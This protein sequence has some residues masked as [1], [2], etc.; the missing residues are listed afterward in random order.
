MKHS[1]LLLLLAG[2]LLFGG[3]AALSQTTETFDGMTTGQRIG[4]QTGWYDGGTG[5]TIGATSGV[6]SSKGLGTSA[7]VFTWTANAFNWNDAAFTSVTL[8]LDFQSS[9]SGTFDDDRVA[10]TISST[11]LG[12]EYE[13]GVQL[14][15][16]SGNNLTTYWRSNIASDTRVQTPIVALTGIANNTWYRL[17][18]TITKLTST[19]A[20]IDVSLQRLDASGNP[21][22]TPLTGS[23]PN[24]STWAGGAPDNAY[25]TAT[26]MWPSFKNHNTLAGAADNAYFEEGPGPDFSLIVLPDL[27]NMSQS[28][29][30]VLNSM[31]QW[32]AD[33]KTTNN[34]AF[35]TQVGDIVNT[36]SSAAQW[37][38]ADAA[39]DIVDAAGVPYSVSPGNHDLGGLYESYFGVAR[40]TGKSWYG[41]HYNTDNLNSYSLFSGSGND[42]IVINLQYS[43]GTA[44]LDWADALLKA[45]ATRRGIVVQHDILNVNDSWNNQNSYNALKDNP[46][47]FLMLCGHMHTSTDGAAYRAELGDD[48]HTIHIVQADYQEFANGGDGWMRIM[49]FSPADDMIYMTTYSPYT[50]GNITTD[51]D[52]KNLVYNLNGGSAN[53]APVAMSVSISGVTAIDEILTG[54]YTYNDAEGDL[55]GTSTFRWLRDDVAIAGATSTT[56]TLTAA[57]VGTTIKFEVTPVALTGT[58]PGAATQSAAVGPIT[59][60]GTQFAETFNG[61]TSGQRIGQQTGWYDAGSGPTIGSTNGVGGSQGLNSASGAFTWTAHTFNWNSPAL[62]QVILGMDFE[63]S[64]SGTFDDDRVCW[65]VSNSSADSRYEFGVQL[66]NSDGGIVTYWRPVITGDTRVQTPIVALSG[67][68]NNTWYRLRATITKLTSTSASIDVSLQ[69]LDASGNPTGTP[70][71]GTLAN[72][73]TWAGGVPDN[74]YFTP[75]SMRPAY[76]NYNAVAG[77]ADNA[78][79]EIVEGPVNYAPV[80]SNV[81]ITGTPTQGQTLTSNYTYSD[82]EGDLEGVSTFRWLRDNV[83]IAGATS[84]TYTLVAGDVD[85]MI[86]CEVT[87]VAL[88]GTSPGAA[89]QSPG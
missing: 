79:F 6:N 24:T 53:S 88:T 70:I 27:Q 83:A 71:T 28:Y 54:S 81:N 32:I 1:L 73:S 69:R 2:L 82:A 17:R 59:D 8:G 84:S 74:G 61:M 56:Y 52:Q 67:I 19:S 36:S 51:P 9:G 47:L 12:S 46:N 14:D 21:T 39:F 55:Q 33:N 20:S 60:G 75:T 11:D 41:G 25:F 31:T 57:D 34:I 77:D 62:T 42:F 64:G 29:P 45:N 86:K 78:Y 26:S 87:P 5:P 85:A 66:D 48:G 43:P 16:S 50:S 23:V 10:W 40:F 72:T 4:A 30:T 68:A 3:A 80:A 15:N 13:F 22:G 65:T 44:I 18:A 76:K 35:V 7:S 63:S 89:V 58:S 37:T 49:R 38:N